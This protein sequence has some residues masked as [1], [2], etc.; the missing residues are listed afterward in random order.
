MRPAIAALVS[1][2]I[3]GACGGRTPLGGLLG[4]ATV[5]GGVIDAGQGSDAS[6]PPQVDAGSEDTGP[7]LVDAGTGG[8]D[9][10]GD[11]TCGSVGQG[12]G[13]DSCCGGQYCNGECNHGTCV[14]FGTS[15]FAG[16]PA[17]AV[18]CASWPLSGCVQAA[19]CKTCADIAEAGSALYSCCLG[20]YCIGACDSRYARYGTDAGCGCG[21]YNMN[22][23]REGQ[24]CCPSP[25]DP[26]GY[27]CQTGSTCR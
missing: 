11:A 19:D 6:L 1:A 7:A 12:P 17:A 9:A 4:G 21:E 20:T 23:C 24:V 8:P 25:S 5:D 18:C 22:G 13:V 10:Q 26:W 14:C 27:A 16:C 2:L 3:V 15:T